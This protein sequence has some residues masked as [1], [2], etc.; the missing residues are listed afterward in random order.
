MARASTTSDVFNALG[1]VHRRAILDVLLTG[2]KAVG[3][4]VGAVS[5]SQPQVSRHLRVLGEVGLVECR[6]EGRRRLYRLAPEQLQPV[7]DWVA[8][9]ERAI[10]DRLDRIEDYL[11]ELQRQGD[12]RDT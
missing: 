9:Y 2:E 12:D 8:K 6:A 1:D 5:M 4:I 10:N 3:A 7:Q 11:E